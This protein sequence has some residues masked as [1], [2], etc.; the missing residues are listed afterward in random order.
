M[1]S[2]IIDLVKD[3]LSDRFGEAAADATGLGPEQTRKATGAAIP[4]LLAGRLGSGATSTGARALVSALRTQ[5]QGTLANL[6]SMM[7][8]G[9]R[10][11][12]INSGLSMLTSV[13]GEGKLAGLIGALSDFGGIN[14]SSGRSLIGLLHRVVMGVLGQ[15]Q[16]A[17]TLGIDGVMKLLEGQRANIAAAMPSSLATS[18]RST[19]LLD[20]LGGAT[21]AAGDTIAAAGRATT[22]GTVAAANTVGA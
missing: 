17:G 18:L 11:S 10:Q 2:N 6:P 4:A 9:D 14:Q 12:L 13:L 22:S 1:S 5:D 8:G 21:R 15:Q 16:R 7:A 20:S 19:G 3:Q